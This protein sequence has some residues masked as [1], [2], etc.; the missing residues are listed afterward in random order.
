MHHVFALLALLGL[1]GIAA[2]VLTIIRHATG[3][4][5]VPF[6]FEN[7]GGPG[8]VIAGLVLLAGGLYLRSVWRERD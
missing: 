8:P 6:T 7:Y 4:G 3:P 1:V 2:G 5:A